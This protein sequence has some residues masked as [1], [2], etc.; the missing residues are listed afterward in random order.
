MSIDATGLAEMVQGGVRTELIGLQVF[1]ALH[2][3]NIIASGCHC[4]CASSYTE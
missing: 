3:S 4:G 2:N 1:A